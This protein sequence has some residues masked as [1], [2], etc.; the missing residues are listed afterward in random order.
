MRHLTLAILVLTAVSCG[1][2]GTSMDMSMDM[3][4]PDL[5]MEDL[6]TPPD[7]SG[8]GCGNMTCDTT[9]QECCATLNGTM[10]DTT[11]VAK[12][13]CNKDMGA[14]IACDGPEDCAGLT[15]TSNAGC[16]ITLAGQMGEPD[17]GTMAS[18]SGTS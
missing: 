18:G 13:A 7:F 15:S 17:A 11:C 8:V 4:L 2:E 10:L 6:T 14:V 1:D 5:N 9:A 3:L 12:G 16:C